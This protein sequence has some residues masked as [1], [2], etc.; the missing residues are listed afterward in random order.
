MLDEARLHTREMGHPRGAL[1]TW[2]TIAG[3]ECSSYFPSGSAQ[4]HL[5]GAIAHAFLDY[6]DATG[7]L[8]FMEKTGLPVLLETARLWMDAGHWNEGAFRIDSG[9]ALTSTAAWSSI[10][11]TPTAPPRRICAVCCACRTPCKTPERTGRYWLEPGEPEAFSRAAEGMYLPLDL[12][13]ILAQDDTFLRKSWTWAPPPGTFLLMHY[14][15]LFLC[16]H[17]ICKQADAVLAMMLYGNGMPMDVMRKTY[18][19][20]ENGRPTI[21]RCPSAFSPSRPH[22]LATR[23][24][25]W[26]ITAAAPP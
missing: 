18:A 20:Y 17:Q 24:R 13:G 12:L 25:H 23:K 9:Q 21:P 10:T 7:D 15:P 2:R 22:G 1:Y 6:W 19:Y 11:T 4:Y 26:G 16:R 8:A 14:H 5:N 3:A